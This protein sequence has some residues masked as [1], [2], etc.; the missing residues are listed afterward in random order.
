[1]CAPRT[2]G[3]G[4]ELTFTQVAFK[5]ED[6]L[7][8]LLRL[9]G[10]ID[11]PSGRRGPAY[12]VHGVCLD[13]HD[14]RT[15]RTIQIFGAE[16]PVPQVK[17]QPVFARLH[18]VP[19]VVGID[20]HGEGLVGIILLA[21]ILAGLHRTYE[22]DVPVFRRV[23]A[24]FDLPYSKRAFVGENQRVFLSRRKRSR[25]RQRPAAGCG[26]AHHVERFRHYRQVLVNY[27]K[28]LFTV[29]CGKHGCQGQCGA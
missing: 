9:D 16:S 23:E 6:V 19:L 20:G 11:I 2:L 3:A 18:H 10:F 4:S 13:W 29:A 27:Y 8:L 12:H 15:F 7:T 25:I 21:Y 24:E 14:I 28:V 5:R 22:R 26:A 1:M 17:G